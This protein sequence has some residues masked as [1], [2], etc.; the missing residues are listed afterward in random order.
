MLLTVPLTAT[1]AT[2]AQASNE[3]TQL[4]ASGCYPYFD[5]N[6]PGDCIDQTSYAPGQVGARGAYAF[7][8]GYHAGTVIA[9]ITFNPGAAPLLNGG[10]RYRSIADYRYTIQVHGAPDTLVPLHVH[11]ALKLDKI[12]M[13]D[14]QG[15]IVTSFIDGDNPNAIPPSYQWNIATSAEVTIF[16]GSKNGDLPG[17]GLSATQQYFPDYSPGDNGYCRHC[18]GMES[19][20]DEYIWVQ[21]N[22]DIAVHLDASAQLIYR[23]TTVPPENT[24]ATVAASADPTFSIDDPA[25]A[26]FTIVGLPSGS[27]PPPIPG[28]PEPSTW[29]MLVA[30]LA[31]LSASRRS[32]LQSTAGAAA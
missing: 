20:I 28:V 18:N 15:Q 30:G 8:S 22:T 16:P 25:Y 17:A 24:F 4:V 6:H 10:V 32:R 3:Q 21:S 27:A 31:L 9:A 14:A 23:L 7:A 1:L 12:H 11:A 26:G 29:A 5:V 13:T 19:A 2:P